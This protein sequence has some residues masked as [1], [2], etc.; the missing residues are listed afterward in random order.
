MSIIEPIF[1]AWLMK[2]LLFNKLTPSEYHTR[3]GKI[4]LHLPT[5]H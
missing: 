5:N 1:Q 4:N 2:E 3:A